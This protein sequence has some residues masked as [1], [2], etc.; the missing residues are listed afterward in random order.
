MGCWGVIEQ[1]LLKRHYAF[2]KFRSLDVLIVSWNVDAAKPIAENVQFFQK[3]FQNMDS[4]DIIAF[5]FQEAIDLENRKTAAKTVLP[6]GKKKGEDRKRLPRRI[7]GGMIG[8][9]SMKDV[10]ITAIK[11]GMG[12]RYGNKGHVCQRSAVVAAMLEEKF[13]FSP[14]DAVEEFIAYV[15]RW[16]RVDGSRP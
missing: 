3:V 15:G 4:P 13:L 1:E 2:S 11:R 6:R 8:R 7:R 16:R 9:V 12:G 5:R 10:S 14:S